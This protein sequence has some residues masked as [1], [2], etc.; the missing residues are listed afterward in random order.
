MMVAM[1]S[2]DVWKTNEQSSCTNC[3]RKRLC[4][5]RMM[6]VIGESLIL[7]STH[8][9]LEEETSLGCLLKCLHSAIIQSTGTD[10]Q[11]ILHKCLVQSWAFLLLQSLG[12]GRL[13]RR[14]G[15]WVAPPGTEFRVI[16]EWEV[17]IRRKMQKYDDIRVQETR[18]CVT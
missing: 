7:Q 11:S 3:L 12:L 8:T 4:D 16:P 2:S 5:T 15:R 14:D 18:F 6:S 9:V 1:G 17:K 13:F 10:I